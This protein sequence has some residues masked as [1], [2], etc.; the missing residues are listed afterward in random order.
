[1]HL[2]YVRSRSPSH[3][4]THLLK[5]YVYLRMLQLL[6]EKLERVWRIFWTFVR[7]EPMEVEWHD[8]LGSI[9]EVLAIWYE[10]IDQG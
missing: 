10:R 9:G 4:Y 3:Y 5:A 8:R 7:L 1:V 6:R 2:P